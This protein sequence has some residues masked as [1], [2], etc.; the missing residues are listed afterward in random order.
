MKRVENV[1]K[2]AATKRPWW[3][4]GPGTVVA[5][6]VGAAVL[7]WQI[8]WHQDSDR[9]RIVYEADASGHLHQVAAPSVQT[10]P[11]IPPPLW[12]PEVPLL[13]ERGQKLHLSAVQRTD[14]QKIEAMWSRE[15]ADWQQ[16]MKEATEDADA[17][18]QRS[19][20]ERGNSFTIVRSSLENYSRL[21]EEYDQRRAEYWIQ[22]V[23]LLT[24]NQRQQLDRV[25]LSANR[26]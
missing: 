9:G 1:P 12:K 13:L 17:L 18:L 25:R 15:K 11:R 6:M 16:R 8:S 23:G 24:N 19:G 4:I 3:R 10:T 7:G 21:S 22:A 20:A 2:S 26:R 5:L 14:L